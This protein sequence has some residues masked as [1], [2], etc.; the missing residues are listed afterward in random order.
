MINKVVIIGQLTDDRLSLDEQEKLTIVEGFV[1]TE[2]SVSH[3]I[4]YVKIT[5]YNDMAKKFYAKQNTYKECICTYVGELAYNERRQCN[6]L[7]IND[8]PVPL[9]SVEE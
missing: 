2:D 8:L 6:V 5:L 9:Q 1:L 4:R 7:R 3:K